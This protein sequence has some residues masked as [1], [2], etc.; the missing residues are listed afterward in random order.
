MLRVPSRPTS[1]GVYCWAEISQTKTYHER[2][3]HKGKTRNHAVEHEHLAIGDEDDRE[4]LED[5]VDGDGEE[6]LEK[7][8]A[9]SNGRRER[10]GAAQNKACLVMHDPDVIAG[11]DEQ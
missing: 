8:L 3:C 9:D 10:D 6:L 4:V 7:Q 1:V 11:Q 2:E 5:G